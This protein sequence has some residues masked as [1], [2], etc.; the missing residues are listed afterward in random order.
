MQMLNPQNE[1]NDITDT[2]NGSL[3]TWYANVDSALKASECVPGYYEYAQ[4]PSYGTQCPINEGGSTRIDIATSRYNVVSLDNSYIDVEFEVPINIPKLNKDDATAE[5]DGE[6]TEKYSYYIGF[7]SAFDL[8]DS[9]RIYSNGDLVYTQNHA[10][11]ESFI[12]YVS[13]TDQA[14]ENSACFAT[15]SKVQNMKPNVPGTYIQIE[16]G[17]KHDF[18]FKANIK[19]KIPV[20]AFLM[21]SNLKW[22]PGFMGRLSIEIYPTFKNLVWCKIITNNDAESYYHMKK[23]S[24]NDNEETFGDCDDIYNV[25]YMFNQINT[26]AFNGYACDTTDGNTW[27]WIA[28]SFTCS[29]SVLKKFHLYLATYMLKMEVY[30]Q[31]EYNYLQVPL[32]FP[33]QTITNVKFTSALGNSSHFTL[34]NTA[35]LS[36]CDTVFVVFPRDVN[37]RTCF[38]NPEISSQL[39]INGKYYP[40]ESYSTIN[41][42]R[43]FNMELDALN[44]NN[45]PLI[46]ISNDVNNSINPYRIYTRR[47]YKHIEADPEEEEEE[48]EYLTTYMCYET[49]FFMDKSNF[50]IGIPLSTDEDFMGGISSNGSTVQVELI[51]DR[52]SISQYMNEQNWTQPPEAI[53]LEDKLLKIYSMKPQGKK[54]IDITNATLEQIAAGA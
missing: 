23:I 29:S 24:G 52:N 48:A 49:P 53:F 10:N 32:L 20:N 31:L 28:Q 19:L 26:L 43:F 17:Q 36:H 5:T 3:T 44:I 8:I 15:L 45:N 1:T 54:Q 46:S 50:F 18:V 47:I 21:L 6:I 42:P 34:Q 27:R 51:G 2:L 9:Y 38:I 35:T 22:F 30:N 13:L 40:R 7:K 14:K 33:I 41:D 12:N 4:A 16:G 39:N 11:F 25:G 37:S